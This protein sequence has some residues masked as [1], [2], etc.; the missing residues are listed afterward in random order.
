MHITS[1]SPFAGRTEDDDLPLSQSPLCDR[2][3]HL[4]SI[5]SFFFFFF[6]EEFLIRFF[7]SGTFVLA[8]VSLPYP[9]QGTARND[10]I[11]IPIFEPLDIKQSHAPFRRQTHSTRNTEPEPLPSAP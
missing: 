4:F 11:Y 5:S 9:K 2:A 6:V 1:S 10:D 3:H 8:E 7:F